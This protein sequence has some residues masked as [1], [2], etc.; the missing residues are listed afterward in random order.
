[1]YG[2]PGND[3]L[4]GGPGRDTLSGEAGDDTLLGGSG[5][6]ALFGGDGNDTLNGGTGKDRLDGGTG[7]DTLVGGPGKDTPPGC[8]GHHTVIDWTRTWTGCRGG[9]RTG[10]GHSSLW[11]K[12]FAVDFSVA[13]EPDRLIEV[14]LPD[15]EPGWGPAREINGESRGVHRKR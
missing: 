3:W 7:C 9:H 14:I 1:M 4:V 2:G 11:T 12:P 10:N 5:N 13:A 15:V 8:P 6:D